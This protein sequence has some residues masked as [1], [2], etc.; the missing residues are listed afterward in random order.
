VPYSVDLGDTCT[1]T[2]GPLLDNDYSSEISI[3]TINILIFYHK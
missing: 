1:H 3:K 2:K